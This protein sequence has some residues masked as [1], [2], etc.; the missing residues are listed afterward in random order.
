MDKKGESIVNLVSDNNTIKITY[1]SGFE[2]LLSVDRNTYVKMHDTWL[3]EQP[4]FISDLYKLHMRNIILAT[5]NN[6]EKCIYDLNTFFRQGNETDIKAFI[7]Y[8]RQR[9]LTD[10]KAKWSQSI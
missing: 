7:T 4:P 5:I 10:E 6:N 8:M 3:K 9:D 2:E 1:E